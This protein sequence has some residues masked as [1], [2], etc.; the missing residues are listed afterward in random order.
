MLF[1]SPMLVGTRDILLSLRK[2][3]LS[4]FY[5]KVPSFLMKSEIGMST[6][7]LFVTENS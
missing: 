1:K 5:L 2:M 3:R 4:F 7:L 6:S